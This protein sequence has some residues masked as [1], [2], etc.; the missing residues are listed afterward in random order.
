MQQRLVSDLMT[1]DAVD[2]GPDAAFKDIVKLLADHDITAVPVVDDD[3]HPLGV[4]SEADLMRSEARQPDPSGRMPE[5]LQLYAPPPDAGGEPVS[6]PLTARTLMTSPALVA[7]PE[8]S[9]VEAARLMDRCKV[10]RLPVVDRTDHLVGILS[11]SDLLR[12]FLRQDRAIREEITSDVLSRTFRLSPAEIAVHV[13]DGVVTLKGT[14]QRSSTVPV[15]ERLC[16]AVDGVVGVSCEITAEV[17][18][19][20]GDATR[21][22]GAAG[23]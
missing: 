9:V 13:V 17:D 18:D 12:V 7:H 14:V 11:R 20:A 1:H 16:R 4:V 8:W 3:G 15:L 19:T 2:V 10:K 22:A 23:A 6:G 5:V 21:G